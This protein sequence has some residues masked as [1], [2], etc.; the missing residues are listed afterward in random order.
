M[1]VLELARALILSGRSPEATAL[2]EREVAAILEIDREVGLTCE[3]ELLAAIRATPGA[4]PSQERVRMWE[5]LAGSTAGERVLLAVL[6]TE[7]AARGEPADYVLPLAERALGGGLL[8][9]EQSPLST[10]FYFASSVFQYYDRVR[11]GR[12]LLDAALEE[13]LRLGSPSGVSQASAWRSYAG[14]FDGSLDDTAADVQRVFDLAAE[15]GETFVS[16]A[17]APAMLAFVLLERGE[18][19]V[20]LTDLARR[21]LHEDIPEASAWNMLLFARGRCRAAIGDASGGLRDILAAGRALVGNGVTTP[22]GVPWRSQAGLLEVTLGHAERGRE[23][24]EE[25]LELARTLVI[26]RVLGVALCARARLDRGGQRLARLEEAVHILEGSESR[27][28]R[29]RAWLALG[30]ELR[31]AGHRRQARQLLADALALADEIG[32]AT[33]AT[34]AR[35]ELLVAG[36]RPRRAGRSGLAALTASEL[37]VA[38]AAASGASNREIADELFLS[39]KTV[40]MH[41]TRTYG[42][43]DVHRRRDLGAALSPGTSAGS[44]LRG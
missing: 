22:A 29:A 19:V 13:A 3:S 15:H 39:L 21:G 32:A 44:P 31:R 7:A 4:R 30:A 36:A 41:L 28:D 35:Q 10:P 12:D 20:A 2:L 43:L 14:L 9:A 25:E 1:A 26:P 33:C 34:Q 8:L 38:R 42:K 24:I 5:K 23:H 11:Q 16:R 37:R 18:P 27:L 17:M 40:E 6:A